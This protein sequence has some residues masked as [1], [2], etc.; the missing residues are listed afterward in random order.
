M[1]VVGG[2]AMV[3]C[4]QSDREQTGCVLPAH[5]AGMVTRALIESRKREE[6]KRM[7]GLGHNARIVHHQ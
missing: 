1:V 2:V 4:G 6:K 7:E 5:G 3:A